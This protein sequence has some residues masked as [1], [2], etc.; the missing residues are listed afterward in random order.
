[1]C[2]SVGSYAFSGCS[3]ITEVDLSTCKNIGSIAFE[4]CYSLQSVDLPKVESLGDCAFL[5]SGITKIS[6]PETLK[7]MGYQCFDNVKEYTF[8]GM[9]PAVLS[10]YDGFP[11]FDEST[12]HRY[13]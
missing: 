3:A 7:S 2:T 10:V 8:N 4:D 6:L 5:R 9:Q 12:C 13:L 1:M 11:A